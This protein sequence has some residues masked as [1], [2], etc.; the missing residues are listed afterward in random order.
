M[1]ALQELAPE[2]K[3]LQEKYKDDKQRLQQEMMKF[4]Q[5][6]KVNP[7]RLLPAAGAA[8][9]GL[10][11]AVLHAADGPQARHLRASRSAERARTKSATQVDPGSRQF[12]F[13]PDLTD[14][15][16]GGVLVVLSSSTSARSC[17]RAPDVGDGGQDAAHDH[18]GAAVRLRP[19]HHRASRPACS[20]TGSRRTSGPSASSTR[21]GR[22][23]ARRSRR[24][25]AR[26]GRDQGS[27]TSLKQSASAV[28]PANDEGGKGSGAKPARARAQRRARRRARK[29]ARTPAAATAP[30]RRRRRSASAGASLRPPAASARRRRSGRRR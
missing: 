14:K 28:T 30:P 13:I 12:L 20:S 16:T 4:Y 7:V 21:C 15:A 29:A 23:S 19:V 3:E 9:A 11:R 27:S 6:N 17:C 10:L 8:A 5:E 24:R 25:S 1:Q 22:S 2:I 26:T 18:D